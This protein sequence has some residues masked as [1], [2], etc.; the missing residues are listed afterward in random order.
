MSN[1]DK[2]G[3]YFV[4]LGGAD[5]I[6]MNMYVYACNGKF[7]MVDA[8][9]G[10]LNDNYPG[11][12]LCFADASFFANYAEDFEGI[13]ITHAHEDHFGAIAHVWP[14]IKC[15]VYATDFTI[16]L[17]R[18]RLKEYHL[19]QEVDLIAVNNN[20]V[21]KLPHFE[22]EFVS[23]VHS[24]PETSALAIRTSQGTVVHATDWRFDDSKITNLQTDYSR[25]KEIGDAGVDMFV[26][27]STNVLIDNSQ[28]SEFE[29]RE[30]LL[31]LIPS[32]PNTVVATC[33]ASNVTRLESLIMAADAAGRTPVLLGRSLLY[34][35]RIAKELGYFQNLPKCYDIKDAVDIPADN[36]LYIC[37]GS[38]ANYRSALTSI[39]NG[40]SRYL[41]LGKG[42]SV[43][44]SS[45]IIPGN[46]E[47]IRE[48][49]EKLIASGVNVITDGDALVHTSGHCSKEEIKRM[50]EILHPRIVLPV[51]GDKKFIR[52]HKYFAD[53][54]G[55]DEV[56]SV[57]NGG[58][59]LITKDKVAAAPDVPTD[60]LAVD[61]NEIVSLNSEVV[62]RRK[63]IAYNGSVFI[64]AIFGEKWELIALRVSSKDIWE[65]ESFSELR[66]KIVADVSELL[67]QEVV[68]LKYKETAILDYIRTQ[69]RRRIEKATDMKPVTFIHFYKLPL[70]EINQG[71]DFDSNQPVIIYPCPEVEG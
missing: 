5:E 34:N 62:K 4:A 36:A 2:E 7:I 47:K 70:E 42:D 28:P 16:G 22:V 31:K 40:Q 64:S 33:F 13:F 54:C 21:V 6:G 50:Y 65:P 46:E 71:D 58:S 67:P 1:F 15:P 10:F 37:T 8:G 30:C 44:F 25:L 48:M 41:K 19:E 11:M 53:T 17:M 52:E 43:I 68:R 69:I 35:V 14:L 45:K 26:C 51:H 59:L 9:Y 20:P 66:D 32:L 18:N 56:V 12:D 61:R 29:V 38:Q 63:Q 23:M 39:V 55:I 27:D 49:Q 60:I 3:L 24:V 57:V